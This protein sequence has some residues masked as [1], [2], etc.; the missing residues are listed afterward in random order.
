[1]IS[2][3]VI[4][5]RRRITDMM[6]RAKPRLL[7]HMNERKTPLFLVPEI[8]TLGVNGGMIKD[9]GGPGLTCLE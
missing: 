2:P 8:Q 6:L 5:M 1:L 9:Y 7:E 3:R 4:E